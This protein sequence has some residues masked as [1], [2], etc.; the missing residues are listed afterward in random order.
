M[1]ALAFVERPKLHKLF[2]VHGDEEFL[3]RLVHQTIRREV[4]GESET[5]GE[6]AGQENFGYSPFIGDS[7]TYAGVMDE[8][9]MVPIFGERRLVVVHE[10]DAFVTRHRALLEKGISQLPSTGVLVL[11]VKTWM[12][13]TR[14]AKMVDAAATIACKAPKPYLM[15]Q[16]C[17]K[18]ALAQHRK[19]LASPAANL[20]VELVGPEMGLLAQELLKL[21]IYVADRN[22]I[23]VE[24]VD[25]LVAR[26][27]SEDIWKIFDAIGQAQSRQALT[28]LDRLLDQGE[29]PLRLLAAF[30]SQLRRL[31]QAHRLTKLG[32]PLAIAVEEAGVPPFG[33]KSAQQ[34]LGHLGPKR[35]GQIYDWLLEVDLGLKGGS[36]LHP[37]I[38]LERLV[39]RLSAPA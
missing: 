4:L 5:E 2:V 29:E 10:A 18:W 13:T 25:K 11:D 3:R 37:R 27:R 20:L 39:L 30:G 26:G 23:D 36:A 38:L 6:G 21:A 8:L 14:L 17:V 19:Q 1:E 31:A 15:P 24:D 28:I 34:Q 16:W 32:R 35:A 22:P 12:S 33:V 7:A 9:Q